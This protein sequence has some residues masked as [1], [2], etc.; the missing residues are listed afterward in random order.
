MRNKEGHSSAPDI[1]WG[2]MKDKGGQTWPIGMHNIHKGNFLENPLHGR[3]QQQGTCDQKDQDH[4]YDSH[5]DSLFLI[6]LN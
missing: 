6:G 3:L 4:C 2:R 5:E 1:L